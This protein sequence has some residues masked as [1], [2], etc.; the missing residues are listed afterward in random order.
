MAP[1]SEAV[2]KSKSTLR[3]YLDQSR[4]PA[5]AVLFVLPLFVAYQ[6]GILFAGG[7]RNGVDF[8]TTALFLVIRG[9]VKLLT[10]AAA[11]GDVLIGYIGLNLVVLAGMLV[12]LRVLNA[13]GKLRPQIWPWMLL[14]SFVYALFFGAA[15]NG[16]MHA[17]GLDHLLATVAETSLEVTS[18]KELNPVQAL[19]ASVGAGLYEELVFRV[20]ILGGIFAVLNKPGR[21]TPFLAGAVAVIVSSFI[22]SAIHHVGSL[23]DAFSLGVFFFRFFA[24]AVLATIYATRGFAIAV[25][26]HALYDVFVLLLRL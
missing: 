16:L 20:L 22:F 1:S 21:L 2:P 7:L 15:V 9:A 14:E 12:A 18:M 4:D 5:N 8:V 13:K 25:Y 26:T 10:G 3:R 17:F 6:L 24:G 19:V 23:G 11:D